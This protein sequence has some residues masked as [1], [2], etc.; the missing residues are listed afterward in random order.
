MKKLVVLT[1]AVAGAVSI[2]SRR[3]RGADADSALWSE[4]VKAPSG[5]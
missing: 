5:S 4:A 1:A 3:K 2:L